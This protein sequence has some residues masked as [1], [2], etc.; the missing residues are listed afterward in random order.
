MLYRTSLAVV[1]LGFVVTSGSASEPLTTK[2][3]AVIK[4]PGYK[5][6]HWGLLVVDS[7]TGATIFEK[8]PMA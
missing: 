4:S 7:K 5:S 6:G 2:I 8:N 1:V 3:D